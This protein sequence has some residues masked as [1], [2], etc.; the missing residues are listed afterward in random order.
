[1]LGLRGWLGAALAVTFA[2][3]ATAC[4]KPADTTPLPAEAAAPTGGLT[5]EQA[6][7]VLAHVGDHTITLGDYAAALEHMSRFDRM[8]YQ[9]PERRRELLDELID[10]VLLADE[11]RERGYDKDPVVEQEIREVLRDAY[12]AKARESAPT[13]AEIPEPEVRAYYEAHQGDFHDPER[14]RVSAIVLPSAA[15][16]GPVLDAAKV[17][18]PTQWGDLVK[19]KSIDPEARANVPAD[20]AGDLG[21]TSPPGDDR[22]SSTRIPAEVRAA[23]FEAHAVGDVV[24][25][26]VA[27]GSKFYV[28]KFAS[29]SDAHDRSLADADRTIRV[30]LAQDALVA[31]EN[32]MIDEL[33]K[34]YPVQIDEAA[35]ARVAAG[36]SL[37]AGTT[38]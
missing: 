16:A 38:D 23:V 1:M 5:P 15:A 6:A 25:K 35:L 31:K 34:Q 4:K 12:F 33:R 17:A 28:V 32:A 37:D 8:R 14:R 30:K 18:T 2:I 21:F 19:T 22:G 9:A 20:L 3:G 29:K 11:A 10:V 7:Q 27:S 36:V 13:P 26:V 24:P